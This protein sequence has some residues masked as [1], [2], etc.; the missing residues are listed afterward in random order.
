MP[1]TTPHHTLNISHNTTIPELDGC[2]KE[3][4][5][6]WHVLKSFHHQARVPEIHDSQGRIVIETSNQKV[7]PA[8][9]CTEEKEST[10]REHLQEHE[11]QRKCD[12]NE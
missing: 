8:S 10:E 1:C 3:N 5:P 9:I 7:E 2:Q 4:D 12:E 6:K 11:C